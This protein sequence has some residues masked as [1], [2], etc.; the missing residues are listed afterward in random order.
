M[1]IRQQANGENWDFDGKTI[2]VRIPI[3][4]MR[5]GGAAR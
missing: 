3:T 1:K 4:F 5:R 2:T